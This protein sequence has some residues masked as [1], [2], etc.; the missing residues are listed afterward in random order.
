VCIVKTL[1]PAFL[2]VDGIVV[3]DHGLKEQGAV[4]LQRLLIVIECVRPEIRC[5]PILYPLCAMF[6]HYLSAEETFACVVRLLTQ[7]HAFLLQSEV[8]VYA[9]CHTLLSLLKKHKKHVYNTLKRRSGSLDDTKL[10][11]VFS[12]WSAWIFKHLPFEYLVRVV[13][14]FLVEGHKLLL[15]ISLALVYL[16]HKDKSKDAVLSK[17][18]SEEQ[19]I[20]E[21]HEQICQIAQNCPVSSQTLLDT[22]FSI[23]NFKHSTFE[24][25][26]KSFEEKYRDEV[27]RRRTQ[28][29]QSV[30]RPQRNI[31]TEAFSSKI[32]DAEAASEL[33]GHLPSRFQ[34]ET[35][36]LLFRLSEHGASFTQLWTQID[37]ADQSLI[38]I[39]STDGYVFGAYCSACWSERKDIRERA[40]T[41]YFGTGESFVWY[42]HRELHLPVIHGWVGQ[43]SDRPDTCPQ[44]FICA[45][46]RFFV[47][48]S[49]GG[50]AIS[51]REEL[52]RGLSYPCET[53]G[54]P[55][56]H[57]NNAFE[58][59]ELEVFNVISTGAI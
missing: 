58:I 12:N 35:P 40:R 36:V 43:N 18:K 4:T 39:R 19:K 34:L 15:R 30:V 49:G 22:G 25:I 42:L 41:R 7:S 55:A 3:H 50:D 29:D 47:I 17:S 59:D 33:I 54:S 10:A 46:D 57:P 26:Q 48:G 23:R 5:V 51:V 2:S 20:V 6:L 56:L 52:T 28:K 37:V 16:W 13:D 9:S 32:I 44:M 8:A 38:I 1:R 45:G 53:F 31:F 11:E 14:C 27:V 24:Q 21:I